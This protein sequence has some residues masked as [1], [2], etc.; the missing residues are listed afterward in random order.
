MAVMEI[1]MREKTRLDAVKF[2]TYPAICRHMQVTCNMGTLSYVTSI[3]VWVTNV[4][5]AA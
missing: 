3:Q 2:Y 1:T 4:Q 5:L